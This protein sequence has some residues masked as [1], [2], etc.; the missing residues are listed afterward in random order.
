MKKK[1]DSHHRVF[2]AGQPRLNQVELSVQ[3]LSFDRAFSGT[4]T[5][6]RRECHFPTGAPRGMPL[7][8]GGGCCVS[9]PYSRRYYDNTFSLSCQ[10]RQARPTTLKELSVDNL[11]LF[12]IHQTWTDLREARVKDGFIFRVSRYFIDHWLRLLGPKAAWAV[13][14]LQQRCYLAKA[15]FCQA[16]LKDLCAVTGV[17]STTTMQS[18]VDMPLMH[19]FFAKRATRQRRADKVMRGKN[20]YNLQMSD[21][22]T[23]EHQGKLAWLLAER[24][25]DGTVP[26]VHGPDDLIRLVSDLP[27]LSTLPP[28][29][30]PT[31]AMREP[32]NLR[33]IALRV[34]SEAD[35]VG[36][37]A[38]LADETALRQVF[39][40]AQARV[41]RPAQ[42][43]LATHYFR[44]DWVHQL[45]ATNAWL[46]MILRSRCYWNKESGEVRDSC[47]VSMQELA[48]L[49]GASPRTVIRGLQD[50]LVRKFV[51]AQ[52]RVYERRASDNRKIPSRTRFHVQLT[53]DPLTPPD[54]AAF[55][56]ILLSDA[57]RYGLDPVTGQMDMLDILDM[58]SQMV[59]DDISRRRGQY[60]RGDKY[61]IRTSGSSE[62][63]DKTEITRSPSG[64]PNLAPNDKIEPGVSVPE[65]VETL[66]TEPEN[67]IEPVLPAP[68]DSERAFE[69]ES[70][71]KIEIRESI[72]DKIEIRA[73]E[74][75]DKTDTV[76]DKSSDRTEKQYLNTFQNTA[77]RDGDFQQQYSFTAAEN[78]IF[79]L[80]Q[81]LAQY[82]VEEPALSRIA[83]NP[84]VTPELARAWILYAEN[85]SGLKH[86]TGY[87]V[88]RLT[89]T[90]PDVPTDPD[91]LL[92]ASLSEVDLI[93]F[94]QR[95]A[96]ELSMG[97]SVSFGSE[98][99][100]AQYRAWLRFY[101]REGGVTRDDETDD[102][103]TLAHDRRRASR[104]Q[105]DVG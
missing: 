80:Y 51:T 25:R 37:Q 64:A 85:E 20:R 39:T 69:E 14:D 58:M 2:S 77:A 88:Q 81:I 95:R 9:R 31:W 71:D 101:G 67:K 41:T 54:E 61:E 21:P 6:A 76:P 8:W 15:D 16:S 7:D 45:G 53:M 98:R 87:V 96:L 104:W 89:R 18:I 62:S 97:A 75:G 65:P 100:E 83:T 59:G 44:T 19:W 47:I 36:V 91:L 43:A 28:D 13:V 49:L 23:P 33:Q 66:E 56:G 27:R 52:E 63:N 60:Q 102:E 48:D 103:T 32:L 5:Q 24:L 55:A 99:H 3:F 4:L 29:D 92:V 30:L 26:Q 74:S 78:P 90:P 35:I 34:L 42:I 38:N 1:K 73:G 72:D 17:G 94:A 79:T 10:S 68:N 84:Q 11:D 82:G 57:A 86:K 93:G 105:P 46:I 70:G 40:D 22:L 50:P 12:Q